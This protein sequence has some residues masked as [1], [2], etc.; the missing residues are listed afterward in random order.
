[1]PTVRDS[2]NTANLAQLA[3]WIFANRQG[4]VF[5]LTLCFIVAF[6]T[7]TLAKPL[8]EWD[9]FAY[10]ANAIQVTENPSQEELH[11]RVYQLVAD[12][13]P[14]E[15]L[16]TL[17]GTPSRLVLSQDS[18]A[19]KQTTEF[20]YDTRVVYHH[21]MAG[22]YK[23][24][25]NPVF[26]H[27]LFSTLCVA[28]SILLL[29]R[30]LPFQV[31]VGLIFVMPFIVLAFGLMTVAR[32]AT[33]DALA[34]LTTVS[35]YFMLFRGKLKLLLFI[36]PFVI[37]IR[38]DLIL[39]I[40]LFHA[41]L[42]LS[43]QVSRNL[44]IASGL[45][46]IVAYLFLNNVIV[47][48]DSWSSLLGYNLGNKP[49]HP[50]EFQFPITLSSY[51]GLVKSG[52]ITF[53]YNPIFFVYCMLSGMGLVLLLSQFFVKP[54]DTSISILHADLL[55]LFL[56]S[57][58]YI[59]IHFLLFPVSWTRFFAAQYSMIA[60]AT[61]WFAFSCFSARYWRTGGRLDF[62]DLSRN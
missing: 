60:V 11:L 27:Y 33:P 43:N 53:S 18:E 12:E 7:L 47:D 46:T 4:L 62:L 25:L 29:M 31:P 50:E 10:V 41:Y 49:T 9:L 15:A 16:A 44:V 42:L 34:T 26:A 45:A 55:F 2:T 19:F 37:F 36:F 61:C 52:A 54:G 8:Y 17:N 57:T 24:G 58:V 51:L 59:V 6:S 21:V 40:A 28:L 14:S 3:R 38:T 48:K 30:L 35:L 1:V 32:L 22:I 13:V 20:F 5:L 56:S 39:L 23:T